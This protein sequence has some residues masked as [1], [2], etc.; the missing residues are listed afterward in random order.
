MPLHITDCCTFLGLS[1]L[2]N[3][4]QFWQTAFY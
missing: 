4:C 1:V 3:H 2:C